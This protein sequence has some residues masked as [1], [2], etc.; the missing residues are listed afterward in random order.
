MVNTSKLQST[1][2]KSSSMEFP[3]LKSLDNKYKVAF[4]I[5]GIVFDAIKLIYAV[6]DIYLCFHLLPDLTSIISHKLFSVLCRI[7]AFAT[8]PLYSKTGSKIVFT[9]LSLIKSLVCC[10]ASSNFPETCIPS[11]NN[12]LAI[13]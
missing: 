12:I 13:S 5:D 9:V 11:G 7:S 10:N 2:L 4:D 1:L 6:S 3:N 8:N